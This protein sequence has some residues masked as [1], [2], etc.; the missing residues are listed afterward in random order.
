MWRKDLSE[1][2]KGQTVMARRLGQNTSNTAALVG[3]SGSAVVKRSKEGTVGHGRPRLIDIHAG[4]E[5]RTATVAQTA[6]KF[7]LVLIERC[8][9]TRFITLSYIFAS[10]RD[11]TILMLYLIGM[12]CS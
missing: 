7:M 10:K 1:F 4:S 2:D 11:H 9:N 3:C 5:E 6:E 8:H 12:Y